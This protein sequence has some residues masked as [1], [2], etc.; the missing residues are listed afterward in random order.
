MST[1]EE[2]IKFEPDEEKMLEIISFLHRIC[3]AYKESWPNHGSLMYSLSS[4]ADELIELL[5]GESHSG[6]NY[7][8]WFESWQDKRWKHVQEQIR[9]GNDAKEIVEELKK[10]YI[11]QSV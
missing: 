11:I 7:E 4:K 1:G 10:Y 8:K 9:L 5:T 6:N 2:N 3:R